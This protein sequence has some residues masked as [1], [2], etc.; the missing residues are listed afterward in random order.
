MNSADLIT[1][2]QDLLQKALITVG[3]KAAEIDLKFGLTL[4]G[5]TKYWF[6]KNGALSHSLSRH[7]I[8]VP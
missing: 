4:S 5:E 6:I 8:L 3:P 2:T 7:P 1:A